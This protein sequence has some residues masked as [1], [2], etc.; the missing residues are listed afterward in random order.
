MTKGLAAK[1]PAGAVSDRTLPMGA[2][3]R[4]SSRRFFAPA[5][6]GP[7]SS[8]GGDGWG[9]EWR[10]GGGNIYVQQV[11]ESFKDPGNIFRYP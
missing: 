1:S 8:G 2:A 3:V 6:T 5:F 10:A 11:F 4:P 7:T 9:L